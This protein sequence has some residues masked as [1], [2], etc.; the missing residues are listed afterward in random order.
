[1]AGDD[2]IYE[3]LPSEVKDNL[4][5]E[6]WDEARHLVVQEG[7]MVPDTTWYINLKNGQMRQH[8]FG[9]PA[10]GPLLA[11]HN[12]AGGRGQDSRQF[13]TAPPRA[14]TGP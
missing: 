5:V 1:M 4:T 8:D 11:T 3:Q 7:Q 13:H 10:D 6:Q 14:H 12:L 9:Q 2:L